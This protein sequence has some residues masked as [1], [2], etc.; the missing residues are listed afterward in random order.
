MNINAR[1]DELW[2]QT[3]SGILPRGMRFWAIEALTDEYIALNGKR[4]PVEAL[5][6]LATLCLYEEVTDQN[7]H[8]MTHEPEPIMSDRQYD[9]R[10]GREWW[11]E[12]ISVGPAHVTGRRKSTF[13]DDDETLQVGKTSYY[14]R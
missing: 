11:R 13:T 7:E 8:K 3:K 10:K 6:R 12:E 2:A 14:L 9:R 5:D 4:P 1:I